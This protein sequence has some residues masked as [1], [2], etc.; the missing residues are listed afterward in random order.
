MVRLGIG[1]G[2][3][4]DNVQMNDRFPPNLRQSHASV[5]APT[6]GTLKQFRIIWCIDYELA[7]WLGPVNTGDF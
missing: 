3:V 6:L 7:H 1:D 5:T 4:K 2:S